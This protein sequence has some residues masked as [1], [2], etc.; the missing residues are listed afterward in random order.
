MPPGVS[1]IAETTNADALKQ[2]ITPWY[3]A[4][5]DTP[6]GMYEADDL[7]KQVLEFLPE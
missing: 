6:G 4:I 2:L 3:E 1:E 5:S 7:R